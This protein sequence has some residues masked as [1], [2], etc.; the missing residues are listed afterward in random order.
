MKKLASIC[1]A[2]ALGGVLM[3]APLFAE[4]TF[5][6]SVDDAFGTVTIPEAPERVVTIGWMSQDA[7]LSLGV[8]PVG[9][10]Y[11]SWGDDG[12][13]YYPWTHA[14]I[15][16]LGQGEPEQINFDDGVPFEAILAL[17]PDLILARYSG[18]TEVEYARL[19]QIAPTVAYAGEPW[20]GE[21][22]DIVRTAGAALGKSAEAEAV[23]EATD[24]TIAAARDAHPE[25]AGKSFIF[26]GS[27]SPDVTELAV[28][29]STDPR[30][31]LV[32]DLG[33]T[34]A[35]GAA[36]LPTDSGFYQGISIENLDQVDADVLLAW[37]NDDAAVRYIEENEITARFR[38]VADG[39]FI[40]I[41]D[42]SFVMATSAP[43]PLSIP[44][45][46]ERLVPMIAE[47]L[48]E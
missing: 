1:A 14:A 12:T 32:Q 16:A 11:T 25:F 41:V 39:N 31:Q 7:V 19:S 21:W 3:A 5:P 13:G 35:P 15:D 20:S 24:A 42:R 29:V 37:A 2:T 44:W 27:L 18:L 48:A 9:I 23:V 34:L 45:A 4:D 43:S 46:A 30:V 10:P 36:A 33:L 47:A 38:P 22:R 8:L 26:V 17:E 40:A 28:Y 6:V